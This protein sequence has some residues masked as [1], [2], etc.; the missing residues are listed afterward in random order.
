MLD[1][2]SHH[3]CARE[4]MW[5][6]SWEV[7]FRFF[8]ASASSFQRL[9]VVFLLYFCRTRVTLWIES[10]VMSLVSF[11]FRA[12]NMMMMMMLKCKVAAVSVLFYVLKRRLKLLCN[13]S[14]W[15]INVLTLSFARVF[16][17]CS[18]CMFFMNCT[19]GQTDFCK[20]FYICFG[21]WFFCTGLFQSDFK[22][23]TLLPFSLHVVFWCWCHKT[24]CVQDLSFNKK[25]QQQQ[26]YGFC[27]WFLHFRG[28]TLF[29]GSAGYIDIHWI[30][31]VCFFV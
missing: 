9:C 27:V 2:I 15:L 18:D 11:D 26:N 24:V 21:T 31:K 23:L 5:R 30:Y 20:T 28:F 1:L 6:G 4:E 19:R 7:K 14:L 17:L 8:K 29:K 25:N 22:L 16:V 13:I 10:A 3:A 12:L